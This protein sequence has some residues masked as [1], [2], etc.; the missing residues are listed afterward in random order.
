MDDD[1]LYTVT[2]KGAVIGKYL[3]RYKSLVNLD[4]MLDIWQKC[5]CFCLN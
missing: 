3:A 1:D 2:R 4:G 5:V